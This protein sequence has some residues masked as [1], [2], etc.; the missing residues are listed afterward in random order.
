[1]PQP[2][3]RRPG[4]GLDARPQ[5]GGGVGGRQCD[6]REISRIAEAQPVSQPAG[7]LFSWLCEPTTRDVDPMT[8]NDSNPRIFEYRTPTGPDGQLTEIKPEEME[9]FLLAR[10]EAA[11]GDPTD[12]IW[13]LAQYYKRAGR[14]DRAFQYLGTLFERAQDPET[15]AKIL[16]ALGQTAERAGDF[17]LAVRFYQ[18]GLSTRPADQW[19]RYFLHNNL[20][21]SLNQLGR[22]PEGE[23]QCRAAI[24]INPDRPNAH[25]NLGL[26][27]AARGAVREAAESFV[28]A[29]QANA[30]DGRA[31]RCLEALLAAHPELQPEFDDALA[32]C[33]RAVESARAAFVAAT[34]EL[35][36]RI[37]R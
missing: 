28:A 1:M 27:L 8:G 32:Q 22:C 16:L 12:A 31:M 11:T 21:Y 34:A 10:L 30:S 23:L 33:R 19:T 36:Q 9:Q 7:T 18:H 17:E 6:R 2:L 25:K 29:T 15:A 13:E 14:I 24:E 3:V 20:G 37:E 4:I 5:A 35:E 26:A